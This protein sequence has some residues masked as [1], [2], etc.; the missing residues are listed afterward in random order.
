MHREQ[1][2]ST[3]SLA[4][5]KENG[6]YIIHSQLLPYHEAIDEWRDYY[7]LDAGQIALIQNA[8]FR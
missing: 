7:D 5:I 2:Y 4:D 3:Q 8:L 6:G 1:L